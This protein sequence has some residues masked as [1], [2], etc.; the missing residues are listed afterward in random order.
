[1]RRTIVYSHVVHL[2]HP[3]RPGIPLW[4]GDPPVE[5]ET[6][7]RWSEDGFFLQR[8]CLG[9]HTGTHLN[10]P[11]HFFPRAAAVDR[12]NPECLVVPAV[13]ID[14]RQAAE[15]NPDYT[16]QPH[17]ILRWEAR[18]GSIPR[19]TLVVLWTGWQERWHNPEAF[20]NR[21]DQGKMHFPGF[22]ASSVEF[23]I[24]QR[25]VAGFGTD[26]HGIDPGSDETF[27]SN[28][29]ALAK[30]K[31][32]LEN[33]TNLHRLPPMGATLVIGVLP[34]Q[35]GSGSPASVLAFVP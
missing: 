34:L 9:E 26:T 7:A 18:H 33:L 21:D 30:G 27:A 6:V 2:S 17:D 16:L 24:E 23:L 5:L 31:L 29:L 15:E 28:R 13:V 25:Q 22:A 8:V 3:I 35:G 19:G 10:A 20:F 4:P 1:M 11:S 12:L 14:G 32:V